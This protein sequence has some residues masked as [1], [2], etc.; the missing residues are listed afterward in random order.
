MKNWIDRDTALGAEADTDF[1]IFS[2]N[3]MSCSFYG[4][5]KEDVSKRRS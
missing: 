3:I 1:G 4:K 2:P 5:Q